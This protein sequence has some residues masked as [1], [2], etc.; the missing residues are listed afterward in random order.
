MNEQII[1]SETPTIFLAMFWGGGGP[2]TIP[3]IIGVYDW[4]NRAT[5]S[6]EDMETA[7]NTLLGMKLIEQKGDTFSIPR[8]QHA[9][10]DAFRKKK[11]KGR[12]ENVRLYFE[13][14]PEV[15]EVPT[16]IRLTAE[17]YEGHMREYRRAF[18]EA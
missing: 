12:F 4:V 18:R 16:L 9:A 14:L 7:L 11:R 3:Q 10:F 17:A 13:Q 1:R 6:R 15:T 5:P 2:Y 8:E